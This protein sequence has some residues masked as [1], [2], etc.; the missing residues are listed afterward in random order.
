MWRWSVDELEDFWATIWDAFE[1]RASAPVRARARRA[2]TMPGRELVRG[3]ATQLRREPA[4]RQARRPARDPARLGAARARLA[5]LGRA[6]RPRSPA[7]RRGAARGSAS[8]R[9]TGSSPTCRTS[10]EAVIALPR[11]RVDRRDLVELLA[12]LRRPLGRRPLRPDRAE[13]AL[14]RRRLPLQRPR[15]RPP[16]RRRRPARRDAD[17]RAH[18]RP[19]LPR[20]RAGP[21]G[22]PRRARAGTTSWARRRP[23]SSTFEQVPFDHPLWVLYSSGTTGLPKAIVQGHGGILLEQLKNAQ[24]PPR[25]AARATASSGSRRPAG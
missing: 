7:L 20:S 3:R 10:A 13:G 22:P 6:A 2:A 12:R 24:P 5:H 19:P 16:R 4:R 25:R 15:L 1:V 17:G 9:A 21:R 8:S 18:G 11:H 23:R 14:L